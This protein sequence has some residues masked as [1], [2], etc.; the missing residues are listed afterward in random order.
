MGLPA[1]LMVTVLMLSA[2]LADVP[3][4]VVI[5]SSARLVTVA[6]LVFRT[7]LTTASRDFARYV[8]T[9]LPRIVNELCLFLS[10]GVLAAGIAA[11]L[12]QGVIENPFAHFDS[13]TAATTLVFIVLLSFVGI[14]PIISI[15]SISPMLLTLD[16]NPNLLAATYLLDIHDDA[17]L[18]ALIDDL[19]SSFPAV[20]VTFLD[21]N[22]LPSV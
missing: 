20:S 3:I 2:I 22:H 5:A 4:L 17:T 1:L 15:S 12:D 10:A 21:Q 6:V 7:G 16:P 11:L 9:G 14:H 13:S 8:G 19:R 18:N